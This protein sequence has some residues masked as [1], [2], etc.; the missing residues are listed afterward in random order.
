MYKSV[1][2][3]MYGSVDLCM[4]GSVDLCMYGSVDLWICD[5]D[6][7]NL[8]LIDYKHG[9]ENPEQIISIPLLQSRSFKGFVQIFFFK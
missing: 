8:V 2:L 3:C 5:S 4:Y 9:A 6:L 1:D 7:W